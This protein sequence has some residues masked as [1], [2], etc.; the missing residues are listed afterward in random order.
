MFLRFRLVVL[1]G[2]AEGAVSTDEMEKRIEPDFEQDGL[3]FVEVKHVCNLEV[4][5][6][7]IIVVLINELH[8]K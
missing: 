7:I 6:V 3:N 4:C 5:L 1:R 8:I 2:D